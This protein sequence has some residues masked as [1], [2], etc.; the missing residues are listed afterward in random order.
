MS[1][2]RLRAVDPESQAVRVKINLFVNA[3][4]S[5]LARK[6]DGAVTMAMQKARELSRVIKET[7]KKLQK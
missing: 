2:V 7:Q 6:N 1:V 3:S 4:E 5:T